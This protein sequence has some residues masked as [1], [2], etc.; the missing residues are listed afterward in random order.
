MYKT[1][2][3]TDIGLR[4]SQQDCIYVDGDIYI[5][6]HFCGKKEIDKDTALFAVCDGMGGLF[7]GEKASY[8][9]GVNLK[10]I[11][12]PFSKEGIK[13]TL[14]EIQRR[15]IERGFYNSGTTIAGVYLKGNKSIVFNAGDSR[16]YKITKEGIIYL[17]H[18][19]SYVQRLVDTGQ[20]T[21]EQA[22]YH[23]ARNILE[24]GIGDVFQLDW[25]SGIEPYVVEDVLQEGEYYFLCTDGVNGVLKDEEI[26]YLLGQNPFENIGRFL[27]ELER[28]KSDN[29]SF[30][31]VSTT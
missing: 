11:D 21:Q 24:F 7:Q 19:H 1:L 12:I 25:E 22:F 4:R 29:Y 17:S 23:P 6:N 14:R 8:F 18:D 26:F 20:I 16:V 10:E 13:E 31:I 28:R 27:E 5:E 2:Y 3:C 9:V 15:F 30:I